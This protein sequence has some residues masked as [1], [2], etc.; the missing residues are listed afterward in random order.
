M[1]AYVLDSQLVPE[2]VPERL[3]T[4]VVCTYNRRD[5]LKLALESLQTQ[6]TE[7][8]FAYEIVVVDDGS[9]DDTPSVVAEFISRSAVAVR[10]VREN[11][12]GI[13][14]ARNTGLASA[15]GDWIA[16]F[17]DDQLA[18][19]RWLIELWRSRESTGALCVC[20]SRALHLTEDELNSMSQFVRLTLGE[21][22][23]KEAGHCTR[24]DMICTGNVLLHRSVPEQ[25]GGFDPALVRG[26]E[27]TE[28]FMRVRKANIACYYTPRALVAHM[29]PSYRMQESYLVWAAK[30]GGVCFAHCD[31]TERGVIYTLIIAGAR[32][33]QACV[34]H[35]SVYVVALLQGNTVELLGRRFQIKRA[36][37]Y[38]K[39]AASL[40]FA[41]HKDSSSDERIEFRGERKLFQRSANSE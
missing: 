23:A 5:Y 13:A 34:V 20:G 7:G 32:I 12:H 29:V 11:G 27:D 26:G 16:F 17:D 21:I 33:A 4:V 10:Y 3:I 15:K 31:F 39:Y 30:R 25:V 9:T 38:A 28:F 37:A 36:A 35:G 19:D 24:R 41:M 40:C 22:P 1:L 2:V 18:D 8:S 14:A 6:E